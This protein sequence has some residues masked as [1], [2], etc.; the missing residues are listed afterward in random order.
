MPKRL[1]FSLLTT[2]GF[3]ISLG[4]SLIVLSGYVLSRP[5]IQWFS[6]PAILEI[7]E[8]KLLDARF[9]LRGPIEPGDDIIIIAVDEKTE[10]EL[11]RWQSSGRRWTADLL[12]ILKQG[13]AQVI[14]FDIVFAEPDA[15]IGP[16]VIESV[17]RDYRRNFPDAIAAYPGLLATLDDTRKAHDYDRQLAEAIQG[18]GNVVLGMYHFT[19]PARITH[20]SEEQLSAF[21]DIINPTAYTSIRFSSATEPPLRLRRSFGVEP[22][23]AAFS[24]AA[25]SFGHFNQI[26]DRDGFIR[27]TPLLLDYEGGYYPSLNLEVARAALNPPLPIVHALAEDSGLGSVGSIQLGDTFI[28]CDEEGKLFINYYGPA[29]TFRHV[30]LADVLSG[31]IAPH[32]FDEKIVLFGFTSLSYQDIHLTPFQPDG[33]FPG[34]EIHASIVANILQQNFLTRPQGTVVIEAGII[35]ALGLIMGIVR[36][37]RRPVASIVTASICLL[38]VA[39]AA[40]LAFVFGKIWLNIT[41]PGLYIVLDYVAITSYKYF[42][43]ERQKRDLRK[44]FQHYVS[45]DVVAHMLK[46]AGTLQLGGERR[47]MTAFFSDIRGFTNISEE[48]SPAALVE[49]LNEYLSE[50]TDIVLMYEGTVDKYMGDAIMAFY[51]APLPQA[52]HAV[53]ACKTAVDMLLRLKQLHVDWEAHSLPSMDIGIGINSGEMSVGNMGSRERFDYTIMGDNVNLASRLE[54][55]NKYYGTNIIISEFTYTVCAEC[56]G[57]AWT[58]RELDTVR[59]K[60]KNA[61]VTIYELIGYGT[62]YE[63]KRPLVQKFSEGL[64]AYKAR[65]WQQAAELF[66]ETLRLDPRDNPST[67]YIARCTD[68]I[69]HPPPEE[70]DGVFEMQTK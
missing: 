47:I 32:K 67:L 14:G 25:L 57:D 30:S 5:E 26:P 44:A 4:L 34:V 46:D 16:A 27:F 64:Q 1:D 40:H 58:V 42:T 3:W 29:L 45:P 65:Q 55:L 49:F 38:G 28:P 36:H 12:D 43:E 56:S 6:A 66:R 8:A 17:T 18:A 37:R 20:L 2:A 33:T 19:D 24:T 52:D 13:G 48:M 63:Q 11:G 61:P 23:L 54:S 9:R 15:G 21:R 69:E 35:L 41:F 62:L 7:I 53:R 10:D 60:G 68:Y 50:M 51:G 39:V 22:N 31:E 70:W 59:V